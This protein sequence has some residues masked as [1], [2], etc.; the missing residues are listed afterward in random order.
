MNI[1][2]L[3]TFP[4][5]EEL[6]TILHKNSS[7]RIERIISAG[8]VTNWY[9]QIEAEFVILVEGEALI[10]FSDERIV[11]MSRGDTLYIEP[12]ERHR[13]K[14]TSSVPPCVWLCVYY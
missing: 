12:H 2:D 11:S 3:P 13:V 1:F 10:E 8:H 7:I 5:A 4:L 14:F 9:D 6:T